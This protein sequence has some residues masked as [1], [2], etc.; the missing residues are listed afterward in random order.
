M[1]ELL[2]V[3]LLGLSVDGLLICPFFAFG[4]GLSDRRAA[5]RFLSGRIIG[6]VLFGVLVNLLGHQ[7]PIND[8]IVNILFGAALLVLGG[9]RLV[10]SRPQLEFVTT[11]DSKGPFGLGCGKNRNL[12]RVGFGLG[13]FRGLLNPGRKYVYLVPLLLTV[14][15]F[16]GIA[17]SF[18]FAVTSS[19]YL[20][21]G[22]MSAGLIEKLK[23]HKYFISFMGGLVLMMLGI[24]Y[25][26]NG[27][28]R[29][30]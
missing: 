5:F 3:S 7:I 24:Y 29:F 27:I 11:K 1:H 23:P 18:A 25:L 30:S 8:I 6:L 17:L 2:T 4:L 10:K 14:G 21:I 19:V 22:F 20:I 13:L 28:Q 26:V 12:D 15:L 16:K 9:Y